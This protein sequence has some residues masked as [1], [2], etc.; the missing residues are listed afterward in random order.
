MYPM[1]TPWP[2]RLLTELDRLVEEWRAVPGHL[3]NGQPECADELDRLLE[4]YRSPAPGSF[5]E[6]WPEHR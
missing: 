2:Y 4:E 6:G 1:E 3:D 5:T